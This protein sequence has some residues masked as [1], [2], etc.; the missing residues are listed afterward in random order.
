MDAQG[1]VQQAVPLFAVESMEASLAFYMHSLGFE[2][3]DEWIEDDILR[4]CWLQR[5]GA[6]L[7]LQVSRPGERDPEVIVGQGVSI[8]FICRDALA[9]YDQAVAAGLEPQEPF[10]GNAMWVTPMQDPD[11]FRVEF[12]S[13]TDVPEGTLL[14]QHRGT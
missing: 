7:M 12:E 6:A 4:W 9:I 2:M 14:S 5:D 1:N 11:G 13:Y 10:V 3:T 8:Y